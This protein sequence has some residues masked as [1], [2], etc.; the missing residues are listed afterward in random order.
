M[1]L[2]LQGLLSQV[3]SY[4][5]SAVRIIVLILIAVL[6]AKLVRKGVIK[7]LQKLNPVTLFTKWG[8]IKDGTDE[9]ALIKTIGQIFYFLTILFFLPSILSG[10]GVSSVVDPISSM[11]AVFLSFIPNIIAA[12]FILFLGVYFC[13]F[14]KNLV[15]QLI[16]NLPIEQWISKVLGQDNQTALTNEAQLADVLSSIVYVLIFVPIL[17]T[18]LDILGVAALSEPIVALL[19]QAISF[20]PNLVSAIIL[21]LIGGF[22]TKIIGNVVEKL[23]QTSGIDQYSK[24]L[25][26]NEKQTITLSTVVA[27]IV[28][29]VIGIFFGVQ[30]IATLQLDILNT[31]GTSI[32][33]YLPA[34]ISSLILLMIAIIAGNVL[35]SFFSSLTNKKFIGETVRYAIL[36]LSAFMILDQ[37]HIAETIVQTTFTIILGAVAV[38]FA[39]AF[40]LGGKEF[41]AKQL[42]KLDK[43]MHKDK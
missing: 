11:F 41:A 7:G 33:A 26:F 35:G 39:L 23:L 34:V 3:I 17:A 37:L 32:I 29:I 25:S 42:E 30:A 16:I 13:K 18:S 6:L 15:K 12:G 24:Y 43:V 2:Y 27:S 21:V 5:P 19:N 36:V 20:I 8:L 1:D 40:G 22:L 31:V 14:I 9:N 4:L 10:L 38:A 28:R